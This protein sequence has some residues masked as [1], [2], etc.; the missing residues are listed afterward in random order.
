MKVD[1]CDL[2]RMLRADFFAKD[3][4]IYVQA[5]RHIYLGDGTSLD[6]VIAA[7]FV[8][9]AASADLANERI[10]TGGTA[11]SVT[12]GG[13]GGN[14]TLDHTQVAVGD[15]HTE[16]TQEAVLTAKGSIYAASAA[17]TPAERTVG[18]D[19]TVLIA[20][21]T[22]ATGV[23]WSSAPN[24]WVPIGGII[25]WSI[26]SGYLPANWQVCDGTNSTPD[27]RD[28]FVV[29]AGSSYAVGDTGGSDT[30]DIS[31]THAFGTLATGNESTHTH[32]DGSYAAANDTHNHD[33]TGISGGG[34][35]HTHGVGSYVT[36]NESTHTHDYSGTTGDGSNSTNTDTDEAG[37]YDSRMEHTHTYSGTSG[38]GSAHNH[39]ISGTSAIETSH[40]HNDGT[41]AAANDT[42]NHD[43]TGT[44]AAGSAH[45]HSVSG[46]TDTGG[47]VAHDNRPQFYAIYFV[48]RMS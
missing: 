15:L 37:P 39:T 26:G 9:M 24:G 35:D 40:T 32:G 4:D 33:V 7:Q 48:M 45:N 22:D 42:H 1:L 46:S 2:K 18:A 10:L 14:A 20:D 16:Y 11:I 27:L 12:D 5:D 47:A 21:S 13:A 8:T 19:G 41:Y 36:A 29:G 44:S 23:S 43:V 31:H 25:L 17:S 30:V 6:D 34:S 38:A 3:R 28:K